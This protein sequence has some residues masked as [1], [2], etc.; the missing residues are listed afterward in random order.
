[1]NNT[2]LTLSEVFSYSSHNKSIIQ[3]LSKS[4][5]T[6]FIKQHSKF[7]FSRIQLSTILLLIAVT[8]NITSINTVLAQSLIQIDWEQN[9]HAVLTKN[10]TSRGEYD[11]RIAIASFRVKWGRI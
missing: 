7:C 4:F 8:C 2:I 10:S 9:S 5:V 3:D 1:M 11:D 6:V